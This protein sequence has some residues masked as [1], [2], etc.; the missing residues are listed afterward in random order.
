MN[1]LLGILSL[2]IAV[3][4]IFYEMK[5]L[6]KMKN[7]VIL[8]FLLLDVAQAHACSLCFS[9]GSST[10]AVALK[11]GVL[12]LFV[13]LLGVLGILVKFFYDVA[14]KSRGLSI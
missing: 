2:G 3:A 8:F 6:K 7:L 12:S 9:T 4:L 5:I 11:W 10:Q 14:K 1:P 13:I